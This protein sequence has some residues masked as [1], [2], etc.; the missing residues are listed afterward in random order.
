MHM[1]KHV[2]IIHIKVR[3]HDI[4]IYVLSTTRFKQ[5]QRID[6]VSAARAVVYVASSEIMRCRLL[7]VPRSAEQL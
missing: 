4:C 2:Y 6:D 7:D 5:T 1:H 3:T